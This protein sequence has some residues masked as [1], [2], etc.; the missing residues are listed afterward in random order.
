MVYMIHVCL[1]R[2]YVKHTNLN[3][4]SPLSDSFIDKDNRPTMKLL[5]K[6]LIK[7]IAE[8]GM[9]AGFVCTNTQTHTTQTGG[10]D[11]FAFLLKVPLIL[12]LMF[13]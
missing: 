12:L 13:L 9:N 5:F 10:L 1:N 11:R 2:Y 8:R 6:T 7:K 3:V 4:C